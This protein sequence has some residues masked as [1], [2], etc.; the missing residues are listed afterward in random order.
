MRRAGRED[1]VNVDAARAG[2]VRRAGGGGGRV[3]EAEEEP[4]ADPA[5]HRAAFVAA[6]IV[7]RR[8][9]RPLHAARGSWG[10]GLTAEPAERGI[11]LI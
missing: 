5:Y 7:R 9:Q 11:R 8:R 1:V 4:H 3:A 2:A 10:G 6:A